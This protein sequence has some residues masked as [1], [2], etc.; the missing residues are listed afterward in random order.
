LA[1][2]DSSE[3]ADK[4]KIAAL[5]KDK[6]VLEARLAG[7]E[8]I[9]D[10]IGGQMSEEEARRLIL[11]KLYDLIHEELNRYLNAEKRELI[12]IV[13]NLWDKYA[14]SLRE[15]GKGTQ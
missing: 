11:K 12:R 3:K 15:R 14:V 4:R 6:A 7:T 9:L 2:L 1:Q 8:G 5:K 10:A 13:E